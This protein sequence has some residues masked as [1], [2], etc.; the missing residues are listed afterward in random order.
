MQQVA[1]PL[2]SGVDRAPPPQQPNPGST[3][4]ATPGAASLHADA[5]RS[6][7]AKDPSNELPGDLSAVVWRGNSLGRTAEV[8][9]PT[10]FAQ[11]DAELPG[12]G[13][14]GR[15]VTEIILPQFSLA[16]LRMV[17]P[18]LA[19][20]ARSGAAVAFIGPPKRPHL[21]GLLHHGIGAEQLVWIQAGIPSERLWCTEQLIR[22]NDAAAVLAWLPQATPEQIRRLQVQAQS[23]E[24]PIFLF[25]PLPAHRE[26]S[27]ASLRLVVEVDIDWA[28][29][30]RIIKR[31]GPSLDSP[32]RLHSVPGGLGSVL[33]PRVMTPSRL[34][35]THRQAPTVPASS[36]ESPRSSPATTFHGG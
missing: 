32:L 23:F 18:A 2:D 34:V 9:W 24:G 15:Q 3:S 25:R 22:S 13:W 27:A 17:G 21:H 5:A 16:E 6:R 26:P 36:Q 8:V 28:L 29:N 19:G 31:R 35:P 20:A 11:L 33:T 7:T 1:L 10:G 4:A 14:P 30:V 12:G